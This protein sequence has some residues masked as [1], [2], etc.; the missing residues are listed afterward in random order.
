MGVH[1]FEDL[2]V[3]QKSIQLCEDIYL[4]TKR[5]P[6]SEIYGL[7]SQIRRCCVSIPSNIA[8]GF[9]RGHRAE[10]RQFLHIAY[11]SGA[12]LET[13]FLIAL[14]IGY[15]SEEEFNKLN[16]CLEEI[17]KMLNKF[18]STLETTH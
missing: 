4:T 9:R 7:T 2:H 5:F 10:Y 18:V 8:E 11:G 16:L 15:L 14:K 17:M 1:T 6:Q 12:E 3:W 13:Q